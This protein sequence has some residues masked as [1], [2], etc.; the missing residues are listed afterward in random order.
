MSFEDIQWVEFELAEGRELEKAQTLTCDE[1][2]IALEIQGI[3]LICPQCGMIKP[4]E[5]ED[6]IS[7]SSRALYTECENDEVKFRIKGANNE[8]CSRK[9]ASSSSN[10][11][12]QKRNTEKQV[13][14]FA[15]GDKK[16]I[17]PSYVYKRAG[18][19]FFEHVQKYMIKRADVRKGILAVCV[20][21]ECVKEGLARKPQEIAEALSIDKKYIN[22]GFKT[23]HHLASLGLI[24]IPIHEDTTPH[25]VKRYFEVLEIHPK[26]E[27]FVLDLI[28]FS[29]EYRVADSCRDTSKVVG[30]IYVMLEC[31]GW[32]ASQLDLTKEFIAE[33]CCISKATFIRFFNSVQNAWV[34]P[35][36]KIKQQLVKI[37]NDNYPYPHIQLT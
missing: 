14:A 19:L 35:D 25:F 21:Y 10:K 27:K 1:C 7:Y 33:V 4:Y 26:Y 30:A 24:K 13:Q 8:V 15:Y 3:K 16:H 32:Y 37:Y 12:T 18:D 11:L 22:K 5:D 6:E 34:G 2:N 17:I 23:I 9:K 20:Y 29:L 31:S 28:K 36:T